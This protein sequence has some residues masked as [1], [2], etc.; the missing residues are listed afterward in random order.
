MLWDPSDPLI[1]P[2]DADVDGKITVVLDLDETLIHA[3]AQQSGP[4]EVTPRHHVSKLLEVANGCCEVVVWTASSRLQAHYVLRQIDHQR[5]VRHCVYKHR[6]WMP[7]NPR[8]QGYT[9]DLRL[10]GR[11]MDRIFIVENTPDCLLLNPANGILV[12]DF[13]MQNN[14]DNTLLAL[15]WIIQHMCASGKTVPNYLCSC[16]LLQR[17]EVILR[18]TGEPFMAL[19]LDS[20]AALD[21]WSPAEVMTSQKESD[22]LFLTQ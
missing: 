22:V 19:C 7:A 1:P 13:S 20:V 16:P 4:P 2:Q 9:K 21:K 11:N 17:R 8:V 5:V 6:K 10:M 15:A 3:E 12:E 18:R 14:T